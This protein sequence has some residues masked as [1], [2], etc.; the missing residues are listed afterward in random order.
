VHFNS[1]ILSH[2]FY[3]AIEGGTNR[4]SGLAVQ[5]VGSGN[6]DQI[7]KTFFR[8]LTVLLP[9]S[10]NFGMTR[11]ATLQAARDLYGSG[12]VERAVTQAWDAV[13]VQ[14]RSV[15]TATAIV[16]PVS[17]AV[18]SGSAPSW[19]VD[20][21]V[22]AGT[23]GLNISQW[24]IDLFDSTGR[25]LNTFRETASDFVRL[26]SVCSP[27][28]SR[29]PAQADACSALCVNLAGGSSGAIQ[30]SFTA[31]DD[32]NRPVTF[33]TPRVPLTR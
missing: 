31:I 23:S 22:S 29:V 17:A 32:A 28:S 7:E 19:E 11:T 2:A 25:T 20:S 18:C 14:E 8:A 27:G 16:T 24:Q 10:A 30:F 5:G 33:S 21:I 26:F 6:R 13:G 3:L 1:T 9:S 4:T 15:P 12:A